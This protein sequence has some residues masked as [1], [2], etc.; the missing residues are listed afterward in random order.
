MATDVQEKEPQANVTT[1]PAAFSDPVLSGTAEADFPYR[2]LSRGAIVSVALAVVALV[3]LV[4]GFQVM[5][6]LAVFGIA[7]ALL[8]LRM[9]SLYPREYGGRLLAQ[10]GLSL[11]LLLVVGGMAE[12][13]YIYAT[14]VPEGH[15]RVPFYVLQ[16]TEEGLDF[17]TEEA[18]QLNN[19]KIFVKG[20]IHPSAG[21]GRLTRF[22]LVP[23]LGTCCFGG[24]PK[25]TDMIEV[26]LTG[27][28]TVRANLLK[29]KLAG[30]F[31]VVPQGT[32]SQGFDNPVVYRLR[33]NHAK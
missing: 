3:G 33:A 1:E 30:D 6:V 19:E 15:Q 22:V 2:A 13:A 27:G 28:Q 23:D 8:G 24:Q 17:P 14:E 21:S 12:H 16:Q 9:T 29:K 32:Q 25:S 5:L 18:M 31:M 4:P 26:V 7:A 20:Y 10:I 11:N